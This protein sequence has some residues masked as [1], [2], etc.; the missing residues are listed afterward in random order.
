MITLCITLLPNDTAHAIPTE[1]GTIIKTTPVTDN[2]TEVVLAPI[3]TTVSTD[4][5]MK[6]SV[7]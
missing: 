3:K 1:I 5:K 2:V 6:V 4:F 7:S